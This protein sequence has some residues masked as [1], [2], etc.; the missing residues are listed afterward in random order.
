MGEYIKEVEN[1]VQISIVVLPNS[2]RDE[3]AGVDEWRG[4]L[5]IRV[6]APPSGGRANKALLDFLAHLFATCEI[7]I[8][9]GIHSREK[10][11][12]IMGVSKK[13]VEERISNVGGK[14][15]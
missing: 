15:T 14:K 6:S 7:K 9:S 1:G 11:V 12:L 13:E 3:L 2:D 8:I 5:K 10:V 4:K